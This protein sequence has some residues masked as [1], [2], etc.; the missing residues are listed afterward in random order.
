VSLSPPPSRRKPFPAFG[1]LTQLMILGLWLRVVAA[2]LVD[3]TAQRKGQL[4]LFP[5]TYYYWELAGTILRGGPYEIVDWGNVPHFSLRTPGY[6]AFL[7]ACRALFGTNTLPPRLVQA[8]LGAWCVWLVARLAKRALPHHKPGTFWT[9]ALI[10]AA[11]STVDPYVVANSAFLLSE[12]LFLPFMLVAQWG[13][14]ELWRPKTRKPPKGWSAIGW[15]VLTGTASGA[16]V[17]TRP[18]WFFFV[19]AMLVPWVVLEIHDRRPRALRGALLV[20]LAFV[21]TMSPWWARNYRI[22]G[23]FVPTAL[24]MG[25]SLYDGLNPAANGESH[26]EFLSEPEFWPLDEEHQDAKLREHAI[27]FAKENPGRV[28]TLAAIKAW[29]FW[30]PWPNSDMFR[31]KGLAVLS[32]LLTLPQFFLLG[33]GVWDR[34]GDLRALMLLGLPLVYTFAIHLIFVS[35]MRY[36]VPV[37]VPALGL[38][39]VGWE[40]AVGR[41]GTGNA[42]F[43]TSKEGVSG[44]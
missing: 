32:V 24:W 27:A 39:A 26:M 31:S 37:F 10:A 29:R 8:A 23:K 38:V 34:R 6:P 36:R 16:A 15:A 30:C 28:L 44:R 40:I 25:A 5:D 9:P 43:H 7:A 14:S 33:L 17:L 18:A 13:L 12:A 2:D 1:M 35:S 42:G 19:P 3:W 4:C 20:L 21:I 41:C 11:I 22:Y